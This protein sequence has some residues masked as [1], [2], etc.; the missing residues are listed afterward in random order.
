VRLTA[1]AGRG[2]RCGQ[3]RDRR[4]GPWTETYTDRGGDRRTK[5]VLRVRY[6]GAGLRFAAL[7]ATRTGRT[8]DHEGWLSAARLFRRGHLAVGAWRR[9]AGTT[10]G[11]VT[12]ER[13]AR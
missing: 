2:R 6:V 10:A 7:T 4:R 9:A 13:A 5:R 3:R 8:G 11:A 1:P 12:V